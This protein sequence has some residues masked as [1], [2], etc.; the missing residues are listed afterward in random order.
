MISFIFRHLN[1]EEYYKSLLS[2]LNKLNNNNHNDE[3]HDEPNDEP[4]DEQH[5]GVNDEPNDEQHD[6]QHDEPNDEPHYGGQAINKKTIMIY[7]FI[8]VYDELLKT[9]S[10]LNIINLNDELNKS[11]QQIHKE[12]PN[13][14][15]TSN[16]ITKKLIERINN[17]IDKNKS[18]SNLF[19]LPITSQSCSF[20]IESSFNDFQGIDKVIFINPTLQLLTNQIKHY[21][22]ENPFRLTL[23]QFMN[24]IVKRYKQID[25]TEHAINYDKQIIKQLFESIKS[26]FIDENDFNSFL[27]TID[28]TLI[29]TQ[30]D[31]LFIIHKLINNPPTSFEF[32]ILDLNDTNKQMDE[33]LNMLA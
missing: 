30:A 5:D 33:L 25:K 29:K 17:F 13:Q 1:M 18:K 4:N 22:N 26:A 2:R 19:Y 11:I 10:Q 6:E 27:E 3:Q 7:S 14:Y 15:T 9:N 32:E 8:N 24:Y 31:E 12:L 20:T 16:D 23:N 21:Y 28:H